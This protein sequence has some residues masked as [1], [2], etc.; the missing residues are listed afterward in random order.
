MF[1]IIKAGGW[2][3]W[4]LI[5]CSIASTAII[6]ERFWSLQARRICP[7]HLVAQIWR[8]GKANQLDAAH[9]DALRDSSPLGRILA[10]GLANLHHSREVMKESIEETGRHVVHEM[11]RYLNT[12]GTIASISPLL[13]LLG[14]VIGT[15]QVFNAITSH[16]VG[17]PT[18]MAGGIATA[19][20]TTAAGII[21]A[22]PSLIFSRHFRRKVDELVVSMEQEAIKMVEVL[23]GEREAPG[24][25]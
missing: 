5:L 24:P 19:L 3:M 8:W 10:A 4:P 22:I 2:V 18:E 23:H 16:G 12:L 20:V 13:G 9:L 21:V 6:M 7:K 15:I 11:E 25:N 17:N 1:E 14:T